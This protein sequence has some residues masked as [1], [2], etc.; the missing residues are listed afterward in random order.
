MLQTRVKCKY[1]QRSAR[2]VCVQL[3]ECSQTGHTVSAQLNECSQTEHTVSVAPRSGIREDRLLGGAQECAPRSTAA[4]APLKQV[5]R[6]ARQVRQPRGSSRGPLMEQLQQWVLLFIPSPH[7]RPRPLPGPKV[8]TCTGW[9][10][11]PTIWPHLNPWNWRCPLV[12]RRGA[13]GKDYEPGR[14][15]WIIQ[16]GA[17][18]YHVHLQKREA[19]GISQRKDTDTFG[20]GGHGRWRQ[21]L[22]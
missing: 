19:E 15:F 20:Q 21:R 18:C 9:M 5:C 3:N 22:E 6:P 4:G 8:S 14:F 13:G 17:K 7:P 12:G 2:S 11:A 16:V 10:V 1:V